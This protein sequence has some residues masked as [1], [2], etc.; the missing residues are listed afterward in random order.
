MPLNLAGLTTFLSDNYLVF[1]A[2]FVA[3]AVARRLEKAAEKTKVFRTWAVAV[4]FQRAR[5]MSLPSG[6]WRRQCLWVEAICLTAAGLVAA[7]SAV[8]LAWVTEPEAALENAVIFVALYA[9]ATLTAVRGVNLLR[10]L[11]I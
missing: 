3:R 5:I 2:V 4:P 11:R 7:G 9:G 8:H 1:R 6:S 10:V